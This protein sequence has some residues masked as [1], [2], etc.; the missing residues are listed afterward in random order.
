MQ[1]THLH[2]HTE[3]SLLD[4]ANRV[5]D[6]AKRIRE[7]GMNAVAI[8][9][10]GNMFG[11]IDFYKTMKKEGIKPIIGIEA[12]VHNGEVGEKDKHFHL[13]LYAKDEVGYK[14]L[15]YLSSQSFLNFY[16]QP[17][18]PKSL[19]KKYSEGLVCSSACLAGEIDFHLRN[20]QYQKAKEVALEYR[21][22]FGDD[23]YIEIMRHGIAE[24]KKID[25]DLIQL[26][27]ETGI[28]LIATND[29]HYT[30][31]EDG[32]AHEVFMCIG[33]GK[34]WD[35]PKRLR[36]SVQEFYI[37]SPEEMYK[38]FAD[39]PEAVENTNEIA[40]KCNLELDLGNPTP[41][42]FK[43]TI[44]YSKE[45]GLELPEPENR[46]S[47]ANDG[48]LFEY[49]CREGLKKRL[50][51]V[52]NE[53]H[54]IYKKRLEFEI[55]IINNMRFPGYMLIVWDFVRA[56]KE[57]N[58]PIGPG[59]GSAAG[60]LVAY[61]LEITD[62]DPLKYDLL[63][64]R[65]LNPARKSMPDIDMDFAQ[66]RRQEIIKYV[67]NR[68]G[69]NNVAQVITFNS[70]LAKGVIRDV[71]RVFGLTP[72][73]GDKFAKLIPNKLGITLDEAYKL[74]PKIEEKI[75]EDEK[76]KRVWKTAKALEGLKRNTGI[77]AAGVVISNDE[78]WN[79]TPLYISKDGNLTT[80]YS[81]NFLEDV[82]LIKFDFLGLKTLD[83]I[84]EAVKLVQRDR[85]IEIDW[86]SIDVDSASEVYEM[87]SAGKTIGM[88]QVESSGMQELNKRFKPSNFE[89]IIALLALYRP[90]PMDSGMLDDFV[91][92]KHGRKRIYYPFDEVEF[93]E[94]L[95]EILEPT[96]GVIV[97]QE[98]VMQIVQKIGG[99][100]LGEADLVRRA[101]GKKKF[102]EMK[103]YKS[104]FIE[105]AKQQN[106]DE[107]KAEKLFDLIEK[108]AG[109]GFNKSHSAAYAM[110]TFRTAYLKANYPA[111][112]L[113]S[114]LSTEM[115]NTDKIALYI[116]EA[117]Q[118]NIGILP[119]DIQ[120]SDKG[121]AV[122]KKRK[123]EYILFGLGA[124]KGVGESAVEAILEARKDGK[125][126]SLEDFLNRVD[127]QKV[128]KQTLE[129]LIKVGAFSSFGYS[130]RT[131]LENIETIVQF[132]Q[133]I[134]KIQKSVENSLFGDD[135]EFLQNSQRLELPHLEEYPTRKLLQL[136]KEVINY[137]ISGHPLDEYR[138]EIEKYKKHITKIKDIPKLRNWQEAVLVVV[139]ELGD[140]KISK[141]SGNRYA[142]AK[143]LDKTGEYSTTLFANQI[144]GYEK[145][146]E[147]MREGAIGVKIQVKIS[148]DEVSG[149]ER[150][151]I[152]IREFFS[153]DEI[154][155][156]SQ[157][158]KKGRKEVGKREVKE[159]KPQENREIPRCNI[160]IDRPISV[161][162]LQNLIDIAKHSKGERELYIDVILHSKRYRVDTKL[163]VHSSFE[164]DIRERGII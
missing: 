110:I 23:F 123:K 67:Q 152:F 113:A 136:E 122:V 109:Y 56:S 92:R 119:P 129:S 26:S 154:P 143:I 33:T 34:L 21:E 58:I 108:F 45:I 84:D 59:R 150:R 57:M 147:K 140:I 63:F 91:E 103:L 145:L 125:F 114:L 32:E 80:Q 5:K 81:L 12:Y 61:A 1:Y 37:K 13:C 51:S 75:Q 112:F 146:P 35:D 101:M 148:I 157:N 8:T 100:S 43:F 135:D 14:N 121:F 19:L 48:V 78:L 25:D 118:M 77:H 7:L 144:D 2:F 102:E 95:K 83:V 93:P 142:P 162:K 71:A 3:Y 74:E 130:R 127:T 126:Q 68:Y 24:Q 117:E 55:E 79:K 27:K 70:L 134:S 17:R 115:E 161:E 90:G 89:D 28:K 153:I 132:G 163:K 64:E 151:D 94:Q 155:E 160:V 65:F 107:N 66:N 10:H 149:E 36:H 138:E 20:G 52:P 40:E 128:N 104:K 53:Q 50:E 82:D 137:Y 42:N 38:I 31:K 22:I 97:Y 111:Q 99:F 73:E 88:F 124:I 9:D 116:H 85:G 39:I 72:Q 164:R 133:T 86:N 49:Q 16:Y 46:F 87:M 41:P 131:L 96:Y 139:F 18:I 60:S 30:F 15:M 120:K 156:K 159:E 29:T 158:L 69:S 54:E 106:L 76:Y 47:F 105:G 62:I 6:I 4:G 11:A 141:K 44:E 98:Q